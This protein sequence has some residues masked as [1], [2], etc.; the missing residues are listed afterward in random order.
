[1]KTFAEPL[2]AKEI[3]LEE[4]RAENVAAEAEQTNE[5]QSYNKSLSRLETINSEI[6]RCVNLKKKANK[7]GWIESTSNECVNPVWP[8]GM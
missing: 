7:H 8:V 3:E 1:L 2:R 5:L 4:I 6:Q